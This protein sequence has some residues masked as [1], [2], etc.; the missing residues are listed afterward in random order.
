MINHSCVANMSPSLTQHL[1]ILAR[2]VEEA[3]KK[4]KQRRAKKIKC[5]VATFAS[6]MADGVRMVENWLIQ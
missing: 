1:P 4:A 6:S 3:A 2:H 5:G